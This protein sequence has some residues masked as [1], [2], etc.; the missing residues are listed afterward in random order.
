M[1]TQLGEV[2]RGTSRCCMQLIDEVLLTMY[3]GVFDE[4]AGVRGLLFH[5]VYLEDGELE[6]P[7]CL[8]HQGL[9]VAEYRWIFEYFLEKGF[10][11]IGYS[12]LVAGL[13]PEKRYL[14]VTFDDGYFNNTRILPIIEDLNIPIHVFVTTSNV[15]ANKKY[16]WDVVYQQRKQQEKSDKEIRQEISEKKYYSY[17]EIECGLIAEFGVNAF[18]PISDIDRP[19]TPVELAKFATH[20]LVTIGNHMHH[21]KIIPMLQEEECRREVEMCSENIR[22]ITGKPPSGFAF[23]N[24]D[25]RHG[26]VE[27]LKKLGFDCILTCEPKIKGSKKYSKLTEENIFGRYAF[28]GRSSLRWQAKMIRA[29]SSILYWAQQ[30][31]K[32]NRK[33]K[34]AV[35]RGRSDCSDGSP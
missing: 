10:S 11:F 5:S 7:E 15:L 12:E 26:D 33:V 28:S 2:L 20:P 35:N 29:G 6:R 1:I 9:T 25:F 8:P 30:Q 32:K 27:M 4:A 22:A 17:E 13:N 23:P 18:E 21:H 16:W 3:L 14:Y 24:G 34:I 31:A 19:L